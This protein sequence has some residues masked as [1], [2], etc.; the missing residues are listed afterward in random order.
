[1]SVAARSVAAG[2]A[3]VS[4]GALPMNPVA[5]QA[6]DRH[7]STQAYALTASSALLNVPLNMMSA[8]LSM[9]AWEVQA[10]NR[11]ADA[12]IGT[13]SWQVWGPTNVIGFD[14]W[15]PPKLGGLID[16][17]MPIKPFSSVLGD[18]VN[19][20]A[21]ANIPMNAGCAAIPGA[22]P[23]IKAQISGTMK[24]SL[25]Q[26]INGYQF[27]T[28]TNPFTLQPTSWSGKQ[29]TLDPGAP[30]T[31]LWDYLSS[32]PQGVQTAPIGDYLTVPF[33]L[34]KSV[35]DAYYPFV[36]NSEWFNPSTPFSAAFRALAPVLC[37]SCG[38]EPYAN[39]WL[40]NNYPTKPAAT[41]RTPAP[42]AAADA[43]A[44]VEAP[45]SALVPASDDRPEP[46]IKLGDVLAAPKP[47][48]DV[49]EVPTPVSDVL[50]APTPLSGIPDATAS[51]PASDPA[52]G[53][54]RGHRGPTGAAQSD[55]A[56]PGGP[57]EGS[58]SHVP[59]NNRDR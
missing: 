55:S 16:M 33:K 21:E 47:I 14:E 53:R 44:P 7:L 28:V 31:A 34:G 18:Q 56:G 50:E 37:P 52:V 36:Q 23:D 12:M 27:P 48:G 13:G 8:V 46:P 6:I 38:P 35:F 15:D 51:A 41:T 57:R 29:V 25:P 5:A 58:R 42:A 2:A 32:Q 24:V 19:M 30:F 39:P 1:M 9:P 22:C 10:M 40:Y 49:Q 54:T 4:I 3:L 20:W 59:H 45:A 17:M 26:L 43:V 11:L